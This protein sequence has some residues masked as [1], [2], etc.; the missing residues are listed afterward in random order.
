MY[1]SLGKSTVF[2]IQKK[3][4]CP[5]CRHNI[6]SI[7][8]GKKQIT[9]SQPKPKV[10]REGGI[11]IQPVFVPWNYFIYWKPFFC[12]QGPFSVMQPFAPS[13]EH[14]KN[15]QG[16]DFKRSNDIDKSN[17]LSNSYLFTELN[18]KMRVPVITF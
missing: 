11:T 7:S 10:V 3:Q 16:L 4:T 18:I 8:Y 6:Q 13:A 15:W 12:Y 1:F 5:L 14:W 9:F 2:L 17:F